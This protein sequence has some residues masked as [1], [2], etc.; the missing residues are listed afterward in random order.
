MEFFQGINN[1]D[2]TREAATGR[3]RTDRDRRYLRGLR[4][5]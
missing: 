1:E 3:G 5:H 2:L 4:T